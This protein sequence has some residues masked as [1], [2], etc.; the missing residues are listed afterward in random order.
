[1]RHSIRAL[2]SF[3]LVLVFLVLLPLIPA[4]T[5]TD[6][7][8]IYSIQLVPKEIKPEEVDRMNSGSCPG[9]GIF[10]KY[11]KILFRKHG[12][13]VKALMTRFQSPS[14]NFPK[15]FINEKNSYPVIVSGSILLSPRMNLLIDRHYTDISDQ[16]NG[17]AD[18]GECDVEYKYI[19]STIY[20]VNG[21]VMGRITKGFPLSISPNGRY[22]IATDY[23]DYERVG[24]G[25]LYA[26]NHKGVLINSVNLNNTF[27]YTPTVLFSQNSEYAVISYPVQSYVV[28]YDY[29]NNRFTE[30]DSESINNMN[31]DPP[32]C[33]MSNDGSIF[34]CVNYRIPQVR[35]L[36][37]NMKYV[38]HIETDVTCDMDNLF[39]LDDTKLYCVSNVRD[40]AALYTC[41]ISF[42]IINVAESRVESKYAIKVP[43]DVS[44]PF[45]VHDYSV[46]DIN[47]YRIL[48]SVIEEGVLKYYSADYGEEK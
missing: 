48:F 40:P 27:Y 32:L 21:N 3:A 29:K 17:A 35:F 11:N 23:C 36:D 33:A 39:S 20:G 12:A 31:M 16:C 15:E 44:K 42:D 37:G 2:A 24:C 26:Y 34:S 38:S 14:F 6:K 45:P 18:S 5:D 25:V 41:N 46:I 9:C 19:Y 28:L 4:L 22:F 8:L 43:C 10:I 30:W 1:M 7:S 13:V 47:Y